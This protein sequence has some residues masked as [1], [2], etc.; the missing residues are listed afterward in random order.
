MLD[1]KRECESMQ[2]QMNLG[3][4]AKVEEL[5][6]DEDRLLHKIEKMISSKKNENEKINVLERLQNEVQLR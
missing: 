3:A 4:C 2:A 6:F 1:F 5:L